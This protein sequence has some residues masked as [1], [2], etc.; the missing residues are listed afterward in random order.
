MKSMLRFITVG[1]FAAVFVSVTGPAF[2]QTYPTKPIRLIVPFAPGGSTDI[3]A[4]TIGDKL[5]ESLGQPVVIDNRPGA[6]ANIGTEIAAKASPDGYTIFMCVV[7][8]TTNHTLYTKLPFDFVRDFAP[9]TQTTS[10]ASILVV[11]PSLPVYSVKELI[12]LAKSKPGDLHFASAGIGSSPHLAGEMFKT[13]AGVDM[14]HIPYK[15]TSP[16]LTDLLA[17]RVEL[18][19]EGAP[20][21]LRHVKAAKLRALAAN[22]AKRTP[23]FPDLPTMQEQGFPGFL[24]TSWNGV[25]V[26]AGTPKEIISRLN[27][28]IVKALQMPDVKERLSSLG[29]DPVGSTPEEFAAFIQAE[30]K[31][32]AKVIKDAG[33]RLD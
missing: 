10:I 16:A 24:V 2:S 28:E 14:V 21:L 6:G 27:S 7:P 19:F 9:V 23:L 20:A 11:Y 25:A 17:G 3:T 1:L 22:G 30:I 8:N 4:R 5:S 33:I 15:G 26:P 13:M 29:A 31:K 18:T 32:W 12:E